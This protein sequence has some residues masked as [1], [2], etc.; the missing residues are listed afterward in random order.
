MLT[1]FKSIVNSLKEDNNN[2]NTQLD[3]SSFD[4][5]ESFNLNQNSYK[6]INPK[7][8]EMNNSSAAHKC[9]ES[10]T[11]HIMNLQHIIESNP[12]EDQEDINRL[13]KV[14]NFYLNN[15]PDINKM[16]TKYLN[17]QIYIKGYCFCKSKG[18]QQLIKKQYTPSCRSKTKPLEDAIENA[19]NCLDSHHYKLKQIEQQTNQSMD[20]LKDRIEQMENKYSKTVSDLNKQIVEIN[21]QLEEYKQSL[22]NV[23]N[24]LQQF[25]NKSKDQ[26]SYE[27]QSTNQIRN[28]DLSIFGTKKFSYDNL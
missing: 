20:L 3:D 21:L 15:N 14:I 13:V 24:L 16:D 5:E 17:A 7:I 11:N 12:V 8:L 10:S 4:S 1:K 26:M 9:R 22:D 27:K 28:N 18:V 19:H 25:V 23:M 6:S 2:S